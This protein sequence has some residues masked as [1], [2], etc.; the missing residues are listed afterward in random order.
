MLPQFLY[1]ALP[2]IYLSTGTLA[3]I[4]IANTLA[5]I[6]GAIFAVTALHIFRLRG[7]L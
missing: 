4:S 5:F 3:A 1:N 7:I 2:F 6:S